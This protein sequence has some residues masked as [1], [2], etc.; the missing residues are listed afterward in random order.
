MNSEKRIKFDERSIEPFVLERFQDFDI[1]E[2]S[3]LHCIKETDKELY[4]MLNA[5][6]WRSWILFSL[7]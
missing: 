5:E 4:S 3:F 6:V 7:L 2:E 1:G